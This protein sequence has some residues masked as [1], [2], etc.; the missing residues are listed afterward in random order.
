MGIQYFSEWL[1]L[2]NINCNFE[3]ALEQFRGK[4]IAV[5]ISYLTF[6][7]KSVAIKE[8]VDRTNLMAEPP[9]MDEINRLT[10][11]KIIAH[12]A[13][14]I[15]YGITPVCVF[16]SKAHPLKGQ[17]KLKK[18]AAKDNMKNKLKE[19]E[20]KLY[21]VDPLFRTQG[22]INEYSKYYKQNT[23]VSIE[24]MNQLK[25]VL[26][27]VGFPTLTAADFKLETNDAEGICAAL[28]LKGNDYCV[29]T[30]TIDSD[31]HVY[32]GNIS[33]L[34]I[35]S[36]TTT[37]N[38]IKT[39]TH[40]AKVRSLEAILQQSKLSFDQ[41]RDLCILMGTDFNPNIP[42]VG[43]KKSWDYICRYG[44]IAN[45]AQNGINVSILNYHNV[46]KIF[47]STIVKIDILSPDFNTDRFREHGRNTFDL[48]QLR[49]HASNINSC[50]EYFSMPQIEILTID[51]SSLLTR[52]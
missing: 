33:I 46:L 48:Y 4:R 39:L 15:K 12:L 30:Y 9:N 21:S 52:T 43:V 3:I 45:M 17:G 49:D 35:Y 26:N 1:K 10:L 6:T 50:L 11:D 34:D 47:S 31:Y 16:D 19:A 13:I 20:I 41:F 27:T 40:Y 2:C 22:L 32:G 14:Y 28:C 18:K 24:F 8:V 51:D 38:G 37:V 36:K 42:N 5:D 29:A 7:M 23:E 44:S 25:D